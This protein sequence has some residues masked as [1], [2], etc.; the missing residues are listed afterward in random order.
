MNTQTIIALFKADIGV[1]HVLRDSYYTNMIEA[2]IKE[3]EAKGVIL[4]DTI[5][6]QMLVSDYTA[7]Q[8][9][10]RAENVEL[11]RNIQ[12]RIRNR[13]VKKRSGIN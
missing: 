4:D 10:H 3:L 6:D 5:E 9:R 11:A 12:L 2:S 7:W 13:I 8:Y 1:S